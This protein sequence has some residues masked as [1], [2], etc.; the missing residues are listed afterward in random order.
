MIV[1]GLSGGIDRIGENRFGVLQY[2]FHDAA[3]ALVENGEVVAAIEEERLNRIKH[4]NKYPRLALGFCLESRGLTLHDVD[5]LAF[6]VRESYLDGV[7]AN[8]YKMAP[9]TGFQTGRQFLQNMVEEDFG[10]SF[11]TSR[12]EFLDHHFAH[13]CSA[14]YPSGFDRAL[15]VTADGVGDSLSGSVYLAQGDQMELLQTFPE[16]QSLGFFY[17]NITRYLGYDL[18]DEYKVMGLAPYGD[19]QRF[20]PVFEQLYE[21]L[22]DGQY[23]FNAESVN[24]IWE[25]LPPRQPGADFSQTDKDIAMAAQITLQRIFS[26]VLEHYQRITGMDNLCL[27]GGVALNCRMNGELLCSGMFRQMFVQPAAHDAGI[28]LGAALHVHHRQRNSTH[29]RSRMRHVY[30]GGDCGCDTQIESL[31]REWE[32]FVRAERVDEPWQV[33]ARKMNEGAIIGWVR[34][35]SEFGPR[36]LGNRSILAD[37]RPDENKDII[38]SLVKKREAFRPFAPS[39]LEEYAAEYFEIPENADSFPFMLFTVPVREK[40]RPLLRAITHVDGSARLQTVARQ[41]NE[42]Y[43]KLINCFRELSGI[44]L[45]LNTSFNNYAEPIVETALDSLVCFLTTGL[46]MLVLGN[47]VVEKKPASSDALLALKLR[48]PAYSKLGETLVPV[49]GSENG[50]K[51]AKRAFWQR[52]CRNWRTRYSRPQS[53]VSEPK[54]LLQIVANTFDQ[55]T[56]AVRAEVFRMLLL[57]DGYQTIQELMGSAGVQPDPVLQLLCLGQLQELWERRLIS[58]SP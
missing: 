9:S 43:W 32:T 35:R 38:N 58:L 6:G 37:P 5:Y 21:L 18:F 1:V 12:F 25:S 36:A 40:Y 33:A 47:W 15:V 20:V 54:Q 50:R 16:H 14:Y 23:R 49:N 3:C 10:L 39:V 34:G 46:S 24:R 48:L 29:P 17:L 8:R 55:R 4:T 2:S 30:W 7:I 27:A 31:L 51:P 44:P 42:D 11:N 26:H 19:G 52:L 41:D 28:A 45:L 13:A 53:V 22:P 56:I 57:C